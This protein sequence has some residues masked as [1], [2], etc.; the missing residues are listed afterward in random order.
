MQRQRG[1]A[2]TAAAVWSIIHTA[3]S[4]DGSATLSEG[5]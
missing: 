3:L 1:G 2:M 4:S 5:R